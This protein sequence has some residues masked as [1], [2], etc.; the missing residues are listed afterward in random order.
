VSW[1]LVVAAVIALAS[2]GRP[3]DKPLIV[4]ATMSLGEDIPLTADV[5]REALCS[6]G[7]A[8]M[9]K[10]EDIQ[11]LYPVKPTRAGYVIDITLPRGVTTTE[12]MA[13]REKLSSGLQRGIGTVWPSV[14]DRHEGSPGLVHLA[15]RYG[16]RQAKTLAVTQDGSVN[17]FN[18]CP[19]SPAN[20]AN[21]SS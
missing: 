11:L 10:P 18:P 8:K 20:A 9:T 2:I 17:V 19:C 5:V 3:Q 6:L 16:P 13:R 14:G 21:G 4:P 7:I 15:C 1:M 12:V